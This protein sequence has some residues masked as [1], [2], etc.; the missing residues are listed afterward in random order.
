MPVATAFAALAA[1]AALDVDQLTDWIGLPLAVALLGLLLL[2]DVKRLDP[3]AGPAF[4][5]RVVTNRRLLLTVTGV[6]VVAFFTVVVLRV[7]WLAA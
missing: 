6:S 4:A 2:L 3:G 5:T 1:L 7:S